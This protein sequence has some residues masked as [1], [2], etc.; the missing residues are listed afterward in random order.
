[1]HTATWI[2]LSLLVLS[3]GRDP[4]A[5]QG[6]ASFVCPPCGAECHFI[7]Y[8]KEGKCGVCGMGLV[9]LASVP[10]VGVLLYPDASLA[11][12]MLT[13]SLFAGSN[14]GRVFSVADT[15]EPVR[16]SDALE[17]RPQFAFADAPVLDVLVVPDGFGAWDDPLIVE[18]VKGA[19]EKARFVLSV[20][21]GSVL[22]AKAGFLAGERVPARRFLVERGKELAP[23]PVYEDVAGFRRAGKFLLAR[24]TGSGTQ[25]A[26]AVVAELAGEER[27]RRTA[28]EL[29]LTWS[30]EKA[31]EKVSEK[32]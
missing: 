15:S 6:A 9:P 32:K 11:S 17:V 1:M 30:P 22:V 8:P 26:L 21:G 19:V 31:P 24:D 18:W 7:T 13:L 14:A 4:A 5:R 23:G 16:L 12:S 29:G 20:G 10:Q 3:A 25:A 28:E 27:A 2:L